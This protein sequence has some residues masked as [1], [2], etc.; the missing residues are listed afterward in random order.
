MARKSKQVR[1]TFR[2]ERTGKSGTES[3]KFIASHF[4]IPNFCLP[5]SQ[6]TLRSIIEKNFQN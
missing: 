4:W 1:W 5:G 6:R 2:L 3:V